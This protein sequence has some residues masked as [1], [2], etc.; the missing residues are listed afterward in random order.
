M[1]M[2]LRVVKEVV[3]ALLKEVEDLGRERVCVCVKERQRVQDREKER[4]GETCIVRS[5]V[6][7]AT[8]LRGKAFGGSRV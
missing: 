8:V 2:S 5:S 3:K 1:V 4:E 6:P 7:P